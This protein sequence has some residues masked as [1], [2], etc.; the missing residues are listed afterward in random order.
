VV[1]ENALIVTGAILD[2]VHA[3]RKT[4]TATLHV[5]DIEEVRAFL[6]MSAVRSHS[7]L[8]GS[9]HYLSKTTKPEI[10]FA[11]GVL[12]RFMSG[13]VQDNIR[14]AKRVLRNLHG[15]PRLGVLEGVEKSLHGYVY[16]D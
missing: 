2:G 5:N 11:V 15:T 9:F 1:R 14:A 16:A 10:L 7:E 6:R 3:V 13:P 8:V 12:S 4:V